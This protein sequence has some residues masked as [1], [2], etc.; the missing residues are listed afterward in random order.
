[1]SWMIETFSTNIK[2]KQ[3]LHTIH[4]ANYTIINLPT[5]SLL[6]PFHTTHVGIGRLVARKEGENGVI[7]EQLEP[8]HCVFPETIDIV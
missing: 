6:N 7:C 8:V 3:T 1:M 4:G 5:T 2:C